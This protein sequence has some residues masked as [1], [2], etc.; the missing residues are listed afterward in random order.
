M[1]HSSLQGDIT[2]FFGYFYSVR[3]R[4]AI[5]I[6]ELRYLNLLIVYKHVD[7]SS[8]E[9]DF[10]KGKY[11]KALEGLDVLLSRDPSNEHLIYNKALCLF[12]IKDYTQAK[13]VLQGV[14]KFK[15]KSTWIKVK[16]MLIAIDHSL[17]KQEETTPSNKIN[18]EGIIE[19]LEFFKSTTTFKDVVGMEKEKDYLFKHVII[20]FRKPELLKEYGKRNG[21]GLLLQGSPGA[22]K[23]FL[24]KCLAGEVG[25]KLLLVRLP[26]LLN[27]YV[28]NSEKN[29]AKIFEQ[30]RKNAPCIIFFDEIDA[31]A[32]KRSSGGDTKGEGS[33]LRNLISSLLVEMDGIEKNPEGLFV[34]GSTNRA[35]DIDPALKRSGRFND[36]LYVRPPNMKEREGLFKYYTLKLL[37]NPLNY[38]RLALATMGYSAADIARIC[39]L[40]TM[41]KI[42]DA[43]TTNAKNPISTEDIIKVIKKQMPRS[44]IDEWFIDTKKEL[45]GKIEM[46]VV[47]NKE[48]KSWKEGNLEAQERGAYKELI[49]D[50]LK[51][52]KPSNIRIR[53]LIRG[54]AINLGI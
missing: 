49:K 48:I 35:W 41:E 36:I 29:L 1:E 32:S 23:T 27:M 43:Y 3:Y 24:V 53:N 22:G 30:A 20:P 12:S 51:T 52:T 4:G 7:I 25:A 2:P 6:G 11:S 28:G 10:N 15:D 16:D 26:Q 54:I 45:L 21:E 40:S 38:R 37:H 5:Y 33:V 8:V 42:S 14:E 17:A 46:K 19:S 50:I 18:E 47:D 31:T 44:S 9:A 39:D 13:A 34:I